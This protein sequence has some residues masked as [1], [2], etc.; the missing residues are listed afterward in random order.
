VGTIKGRMMDCT[1]SPPK[2]VLLGYKGPG[3]SGP[4]F[5]AAYDNCRFS[6]YKTPSMLKTEIKG[7]L[8]IILTKDLPLFVYN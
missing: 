5:L 7:L 4:R 1:Y 3:N 6:S 8:K 2:S